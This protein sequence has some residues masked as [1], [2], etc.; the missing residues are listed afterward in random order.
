MK[1]PIE[2]LERQGYRR[3]VVHDDLEVYER[4]KDY[5]AYN[6]KDGEVWKIT[7]PDYQRILRRDQDDYERDLK[8]IR[9]FI[10]EKQRTM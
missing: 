5:R 4:G 6:R 8:K 1:T 9:Q 2:Q 10:V 7:E 3:K